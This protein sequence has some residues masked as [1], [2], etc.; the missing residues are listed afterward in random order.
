MADVSEPWRVVLSE[1]RTFL[2]VSYP[3]YE[4]AVDLRQNRSEP[5]LLRSSERIPDREV[6]MNF[7]S[8]HNP[9]CATFPSTTDG[10]QAMTAEETALRTLRQRLHEVADALVRTAANMQHT[11]TCADATLSK[12]VV[13]P[14]MT[15]LPE[16]GPV[17][18]DWAIGQAAAMGQQVARETC[19]S[20]QAH[21]NECPPCPPQGEDSMRAHLNELNSEDPDTVFIVRKIHKLGGSAR[22]I[23]AKYFS[24]Y[25]EVTRVL[26]AD[27]K[28][29]GGQSPGHALM[30]RAGNLGFIVMKSADIVEKIMANGSEHLIDRVRIRVQKFE[31]QAKSDDCMAARVRLERHQVLLM[32]AACNAFTQHSGNRCSGDVTMA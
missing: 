1:K 5:D 30:R 8:R 12:A 28:V 29:K 6:I 23:L 4:D 11:P 21:L 22:N 16:D 10:A 7:G 20:G 14:R 3:D 15:V 27:S 32:Q 13:P 18:E 9:E 24:Q 31:P 25:G 19:K 17:A 2:D 26:V